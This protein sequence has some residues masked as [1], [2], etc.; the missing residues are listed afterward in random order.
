MVVPEGWI[1]NGASPENAPVYRLV[2]VSRK[3][4]NRGNQ[5]KSSGIPELRGKI[6][7]TGKAIATRVHKKDFPREKRV[8]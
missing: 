2:R 1:I 8:A 5:E 7:E 6:R 3:V 4:T